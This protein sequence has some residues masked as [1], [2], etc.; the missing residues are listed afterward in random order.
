M[1]AEGAKTV[2]YERDVFTFLRSPFHKFEEE[3]LTLIDAYQE[4]MS[5]RG[6]VFRQNIVWKIITPT[7]W[8]RPS[9]NLKIDLKI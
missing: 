1:P 8:I 2:F 3:V 6:I 7:S 5:K 9:K 4:K